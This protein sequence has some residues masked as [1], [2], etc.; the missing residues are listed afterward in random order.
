MVEKALEDYEPI[1]FNFLDEDLMI[2][3]H[4]EEESLENNCWKL[5]FDRASNVLGHEIATILVTP[6]GEILSL[7]G[8]VRF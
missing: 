3:S 5:F 6:E 1:N 7:H 8:Q 2:V 4:D